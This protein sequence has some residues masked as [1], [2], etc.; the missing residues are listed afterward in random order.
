MGQQITTEKVI[1]NPASSADFS[2][3]S[4]NKTKNA[5]S[6]S[7]NI[8]SIAISWYNSC[9]ASYYTRPTGQRHSMCEAHAIILID[10]IFA[11]SEVN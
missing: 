6:F 2:H 10:I 4:R 3:S 8:V 1:Y 7:K 9:E 5:P 11:S